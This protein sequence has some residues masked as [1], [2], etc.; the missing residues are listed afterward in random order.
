MKI[1][2]GYNQVM[3][4]L[5]LPDGEK[6]FDF[7]AKV[8]GA[9]EKER[10][11]LDNVFKHGEIMIGNCCIMFSSTK[12]DWQPQPAG[13]FIYV[14]D[15]DQTFKKALENGCETVMEVTDQ[16]YGRSGGVKDPFGNTWWIC[17]DTS[18]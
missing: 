10:S 18:Q 3:P 4:Y 12:D 8:F 6:F 2:E 17:T 9:T 11:F 15:A 14:A 1:P 16:P 5:I 13:L 7:T